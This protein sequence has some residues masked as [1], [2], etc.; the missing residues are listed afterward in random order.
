[1]CY[2]QPLHILFLSLSHKYMNQT[3]TSMVQSQLWLFNV[4][5]GDGTWYFSFSTTSIK[6]PNVSHYK[7][8]DVTEC[9]SVIGPNRQ[10]DR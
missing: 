2:F 6:V 10:T 7:T 3:D 1:M 9:W 8:C 4:S 5:I